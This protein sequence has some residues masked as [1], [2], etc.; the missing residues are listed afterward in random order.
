MYRKKKTTG[1]HR[2]K[3]FSFV[4]NVYTNTKQAVTVETSVGKKGGDWLI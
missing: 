1:W 2:N 3:P 4:C